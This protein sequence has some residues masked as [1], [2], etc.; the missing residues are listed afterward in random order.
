MRRSDP[1][2]RSVWIGG[3]LVSLAILWSISL[4]VDISF[5]N[6]AAK[7]AEDDWARIEAR[8]KEVTNWVSRTEI[9]DA[10][11]AG[12]DRL[13]TNRI[14]WANILNSLQNSM[15]DGVQV[16]LFKGDQ[17]YT[18][19]EAVAAKGKV[20]GQP[21]SST[22]KIS[23]TIEAKDWNP[24]GQTYNQFKKSLSNFPYF[25]QHL[26]RGD[27]FVL[28]R[29]SGVTTE[30]DSGKQSL[31]FTLECRFPEVRRDE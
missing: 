28:D 12:L 4:V 2:K 9:V 14:L 6:A 18:L 13:S 11:L 5:E 30:Q 20:K 21:A 25:R 17:T 10:R 1:V 31:A 27:G 29:L 22:E 8:H 19:A 7:R 23:L 15:V 26:G 3:F 16:T 24:D